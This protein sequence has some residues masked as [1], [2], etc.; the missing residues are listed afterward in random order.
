MLFY[1]PW[2]NQQ[3]RVYN[4][5]I[6]LHRDIDK[7]RDRLREKQEDLADEMKS[8]QRKKSKGK[9]SAVEIEEGNIEISKM[10]MKIKDIEED[11]YK[12]EKKLRKIKD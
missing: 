6:L 9:L 8:F 10:Q 3:I 12:E 4:C 7:I 11:L 1:F 2:R 5:K